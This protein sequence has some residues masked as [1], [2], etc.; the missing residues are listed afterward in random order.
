M[1]VIVCIA[2]ALL[3]H[4]VLGWEWTLLAGVL[5]GLMLQH[6]GWLWGGIS[7]A[8]GWGLLVAYNFIVAPEPVGE[9]VDVTGQILG[10]L[11]GIVVVG[12]TVCIGAVLGILGGLLGAQVAQVVPALRLYKPEVVS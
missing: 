3:L 11:P 10:N 12:L 9:M 2:L 6:K 7:V 8:A 5:S 1:K 4:L